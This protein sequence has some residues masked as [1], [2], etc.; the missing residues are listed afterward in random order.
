MA[1]EKLT[2]SKKKEAKD[3]EAKQEKPKAR[4]ID[5]EQMLRFYE[6]G[7]DKMKKEMRIDRLL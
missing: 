7:V 4:R 1:K 5:L 3:S 6:R 2:C